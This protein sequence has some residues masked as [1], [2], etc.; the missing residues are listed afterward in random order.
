MPTH[1]AYEIDSYT[2]RPFILKIAVQTQWTEMTLKFSAEKRR[3]L[4]AAG[5]ASFLR[6]EEDEIFVGAGP[7]C[8]V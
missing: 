3:G 5:V 8:T 4:A 6:T 2:S 1:M 7:C